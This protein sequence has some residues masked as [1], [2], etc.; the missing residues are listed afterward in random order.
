MISQR[1]LS[2]EISAMCVRSVEFMPNTA[3]MTFRCRLARETMSAL[4]QFAVAMRV[5]L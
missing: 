5:L 3:S 4:S 1:L 2:I